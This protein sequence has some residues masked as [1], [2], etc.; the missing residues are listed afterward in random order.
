EPRGGQEARRRAA[1]EVPAGRGQPRRGGRAGRCR[2]LTADDLRGHGRPSPPRPSPGKG[3]GLFLF[4]PGPARGG[5]RCI[6]EET[7]IVGARTVAYPVGDL[8]AGNR[9]Y[10]EVLGQ[11]PYFDEPFYVGFNV[12]GFELGLVP[13]ARPGTDGAQALWGV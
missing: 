6:R 12:G 4:Q 7:M 1:R 8:E 13:D 3:G 2:R 10:A 11:A 9:W 5:G